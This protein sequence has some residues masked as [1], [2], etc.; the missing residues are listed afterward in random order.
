MDRIHSSTVISPTAEISE[1]VTIGPF[2]VIG[3]D[4][5]IGAGT[6]IGSNV[7]IVGHTEIGSECIIAPGAVIGTPPQDLSYKNEK[8]FVKIGNKTQIREYVTVNRASGEGTATVVGEN[9]MLMAYSHLGH[10]CQLGNNI[11]VANTVS[12][13][14]HVTVGDY[15][16]IGGT[17]VV[18][19]FVKIGKLSI[20]SGFSGTRQ[21]IPPFSIAD[22]RPA[23][24]RGIN[25]VGLKRRGL[26]KDEI[27]NLKKAFRLIWFQP[28]KNMKAALEKVEAEV[29]IDHNIKDLI[30]F[31]RDS[32]R[33]V[34]L[35]KA[36]MEQEDF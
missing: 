32:K 17:V 33:G 18:H 31:I 24:I 8:T 15:A 4:V 22:G 5:K 19:Q 28:N 6:V 11:I 12:L 29:P 10:N 16:F 7:T 20:I 36:V 1:D 14:G 35:K 3:P 9:C 30:D 26:P 34:N 23:V 13:A 27:D 2:T 25:R 21:D